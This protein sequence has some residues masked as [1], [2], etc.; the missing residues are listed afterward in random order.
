MSAL[1][2]LLS[3]LHNM[4][5]GIDSVILTL[6]HR[7]TAIMHT[8]LLTFAAVCISAA[9]LCPCQASFL[10]SSQW[11][12]ASSGCCFH[13]KLFFQ[14][15]CHPQA[16]NHQ[17][18]TAYSTF[19]PVDLLT[20]VLLNVLCTLIGHWVHERVIVALC[21]YIHQDRSLLFWS[22]LDIYYFSSPRIFSKIKSPAALCMQ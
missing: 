13:A 6:F 3:M 19:R 10:W 7:K 5:A 18:R 12:C 1:Q 8:I 16:C 17:S 20:I 21:Q 9:P 22:K 4:Q 15:P 11:I 2:I 14:K